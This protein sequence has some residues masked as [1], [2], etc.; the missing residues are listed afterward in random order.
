MQQ[1]LSPEGVLAALDEPVTLLDGSTASAAGA[2][3]LGD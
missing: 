2:S 1:A 3:P